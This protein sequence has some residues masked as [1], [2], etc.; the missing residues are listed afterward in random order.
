MYPCLVAEVLSYFPQLTAKTSQDVTFQ[1][2]EVAPQGQRWL[3]MPTVLGRYTALLGSGLEAEP[4]MGKLILLQLHRAQCQACRTYVLQVT[5]SNGLPAAA[6]SCV[7]T[8]SS[9]A[10]G[11]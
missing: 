11:G 4:G 5:V 3:L 6:G 9:P 1:N 2:H 7:L 10:Q 8:K